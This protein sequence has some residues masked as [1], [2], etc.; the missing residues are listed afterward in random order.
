MYRESKASERKKGWWG[1]GSTTSHSVYNPTITFRKSLS[2]R[3]ILFIFKLKSNQKNQSIFNT[4]FSN[5]HF[6]PEWIGKTLDFFLSLGHKQ[7]FIRQHQTVTRARCQTFSSFVGKQDLMPR[8][9]SG[10]S[11]LNLIKTF[12]GSWLEYIDHTILSIHLKYL[13]QE[14]DRIESHQDH[15]LD[16]W[17]NRIVARVWHVSSLRA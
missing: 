6:D 5:L 3:S 7:N 14:R 4:G 8:R 9:K 11:I 16:K 17:I 2:G 13:E 1:H 10:G 15:H 12:V